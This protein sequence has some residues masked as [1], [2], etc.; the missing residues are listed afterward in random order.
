MNSM[1]YSR[2]SYWPAG[3]IS[4]VFLPILF[5][6]FMQYSPFARIKSAMEISLL[7][8]NYREVLGGSSAN[9]D[10]PPDGIWE[11]FSFTQSETENSK[12][13]TNLRQALKRFY[14]LPDTLKG[15]E[16][17]FDKRT[18]YKRFVFI[19]D[20]LNMEEISSRFMV[21]G[22]SIWIPRFHHLRPFSNIDSPRLWK[23]IPPSWPQTAINMVNQWKT[24]LL[25]DIPQIP[26]PITLAWVG[27]FF[28][29]IIGINRRLKIQTRRRLTSRSS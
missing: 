9:F 6:L 21:I 15:I 29:N 13:Y 26:I 24:L 2:K 27:L 1:N 7:P 19:M 28:F 12:I 18:P 25:L 11:V 16:I 4:L 20:I 5:L 22:S 8:S 10:I 17:R 23:P 3:L 14:P